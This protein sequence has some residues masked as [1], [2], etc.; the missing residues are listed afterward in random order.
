L[1]FYWAGVD[2]VAY[3]PTVKAQSL[4]SLP[5]LILPGKLSSPH[6]H[7]LVIE[8]SADH[9]PVAGLWA[10]STPRWPEIK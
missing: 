10:L 7:G 1:V 3:L 8:G 9:V 4:G 6:L 5:L 2:E